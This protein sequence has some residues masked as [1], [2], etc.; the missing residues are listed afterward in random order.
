M[1][2]TARLTHDL[3][4]FVVAIAIGA[5]TAGESLVLEAY[6]SSVSGQNSAGST[7]ASALIAE[8]ASALERGDAVAAR[9]FFQRALRVDPNNVEAHTYLGVLADRAGELAEAERHFAAA[10]IAN[11][12]SPAARNNHGA[13][14]LRMGRIKQ[15]AAQFETSLRLDKNQPSALINLAQIRFTSGT[16]DALRAARDLFERARAIAPDAEI[17]RSLIIIAL[18]LNDTRAAAEYYRDYAAR[19]S[20]ATGDV[21]R[22]SARAE[23]G[24][25][26][27]AAG[28]AGEAAEELSAVLTA[29]PANIN[30]VV[31]LARAHLERKD[32]PAAGRTLEGAVAR[33]IDAA[34]IYAAL[35]EV[36]EK[37]KHIENAIPAMRLAIQRDPNNEAYRFRYAM[38]LTDTQAPAAA[39]IR[40]QEALQQFPRSPRLWFALGVAHMAEHKSD[41]AIK[42]FTRALELDA[43]FAPALAYLGVA[44]DEQGRYAEAITYYERALAVDE[45]LSIVHYLLAEALLKQNANDT[46]RAETHLTRAVALD[47]TF[48]RARL[49]LGKIYART[50]RLSEAITHLERAIALDAN[51][52]EAYYQLGRIYMRLKRTAEAQTALATFKRLSD[53]Q[54][55]QSQSERRE[56]VRRLANVRF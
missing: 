40:L 35:A 5:V 44:Y 38:L 31:L 9:A 53:T 39:V 21:A 42:A 27:L 33:G 54:K 26:L 41:L 37:S 8:G 36:Y 43:K 7:Q 29:E 10:A 20:S 52:A 50:D 48:A 23:L 11:P 30:A 13:I 22:P 19:L 49:S 16:P 47:Q 34:P 25:A 51:L 1:R 3:L 15:A 12:L 24:A 14:L 28:L 32:I 2:I 17:A 6:A 18:R 4:S 46:L 45:R 56:M 55:E